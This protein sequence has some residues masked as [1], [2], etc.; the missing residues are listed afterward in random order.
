MANRINKI[1]FQHHKKIN[2]EIRWAMNIV[3]K[4]W[5]LESLPH[6]YMC[7]TQ[8][9]RSMVLILHHAKKIKQ[10]SDDDDDVDDD[11]D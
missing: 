8:S 5:R 9:G 7:P 10:Y 6:P 4:P 3:T 11:D 2:T 1:Y